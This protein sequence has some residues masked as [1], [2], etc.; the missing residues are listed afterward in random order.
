MFFSKLFLFTK[1]TICVDGYTFLVLVDYQVLDEF[2][3]PYLQETLMT[4]NNISLFHTGNYTRVG[5]GQ[6]EIQVKCTK[7]MLCLLFYPSSQARAK[8]LKLSSLYP[9][10]LTGKGPVSYYFYISLIGS[11]QTIFYKYWICS[12]YLKQYNYNLQL[13][14]FTIT[15]LSQAQSIHPQPVK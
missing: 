3:L 7:K 4:F 1:Q 11:I 5:T 2:Q 13:F 12:I 10:E 8:L 6:F 9:T 15:L 14:N